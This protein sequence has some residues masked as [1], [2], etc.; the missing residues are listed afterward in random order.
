[1]T[2]QQI[3]NQIHETASPEYRSRIGLAT[4]E[5]LPEIYATIMEWPSAK[6]EF[7]NALTNKIIKTVFYSKVFSNPLAMLHRGKIP[8]GSGIEQLFVEMAEKKN[9][10]DHFTGSTTAEGD[11]IRQQDSNVNVRYITQNFMYKYKVSIS[12]ER[13]KTAFV[14]GTGLA[15][16]VNQLVNSVISAAY[17]DE[18]EDMKKIIMNLPAGTDM[19]GTPIEGFTSL[20]TSSVPTYSTAPSSLAETIRA[21]AGRLTFPSTAYNPSGVKTWSN[22]EDLVFITTP[23]INAKLDVSV[24]AQAF[25]VGSADIQVRTILVDEL[26]TVGGK[27]TLGVLA[28]KDFIQ[29]W[30][31]TFET[32]TFENADLLLTNIFAHKRGIMAECLFANVVYITA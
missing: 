10:G 19:N 28:D 3:M 26:P 29:S 17:Y 1:M 30:D 2:N 31:T 12:D 5:N 24:L 18:F 6:N 8:F 23:E 27:A 4:D 9:F 15:D 16:M 21:L 7:I 22:R 20:A 32:R 13:L 11:L 25:N 14:S